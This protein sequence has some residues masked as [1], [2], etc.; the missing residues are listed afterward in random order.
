MIIPD[1]VGKTISVYNG[2]SWIPV[3]ITEGLVEHKLGEFAATRVFRG[4]SSDKGAT[5]K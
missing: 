5:R 3:Y 1:M 2:K 4:H